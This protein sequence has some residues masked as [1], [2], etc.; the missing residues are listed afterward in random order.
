MSAKRVKKAGTAKR[1]AR[2]AETA[3]EEDHIDG[4]DIEISDSDATPDSELPPAK[5]GVAGGKR[6]R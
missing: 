6:G 3:H 5:G 2:Q 4:C 1:A